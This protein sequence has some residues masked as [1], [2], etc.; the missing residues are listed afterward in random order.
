MG[1]NVYVYANWKDFSFLN[2]NQ[3]KRHFKC[4]GYLKFSYYLILQGNFLFY[5]NQ[6][7]FDY[8]VPLTFL[9][10]FWS[11]KLKFIIMFFLP[12]YSVLT[13][14]FFIIGMY[15]VWLMSDW[16]LRL[17]SYW[18]IK[19]LF[20]HIWLYM[21]RVIR[22]FYIVMWWIND[23]TVWVAQLLTDWRLDCL[24]RVKFCLFDMFHGE[25]IATLTL[26]YLKLFNYI[27]K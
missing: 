14:I 23:C 13:L 10:N 22:E 9:K 15:S 16:L 7:E 5:R 2:W 25:I 20:Y 21:Q 17:I 24:E 8:F 1:L 19:I 27:I 12:N 3:N 26:T 18:Y 11:P 6:S 4:Q